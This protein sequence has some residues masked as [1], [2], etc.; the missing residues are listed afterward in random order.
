[1]KNLVKL[2]IIVTIVIGCTFV[3][4]AQTSLKIGH[5]DF[6]T[7]LAAM[8]GI[9][10]VKI[11]LQGY[12]K[13][14]TDQMDAMK[15]EFENKYMD[16]QSQAS[17]MSDL[18]KQTKE[19]EL[20]D[21]QAR[22]DAFQQKANQDLQAKQQELVAPFIEKAK[23]AIREIAKENKYTYILNAI[24]DVVIYKEEADDVMPLVKKKLNIQ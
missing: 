6:N 18:I 1:M 24:E 8:P 3:S 19:K 13:T 9:D 4:H 20:S 2:F 7:L 15:A 16:Y 22:I 21:L 17:G 12:Q 5:I 10:S 14:L 23:T 11:K